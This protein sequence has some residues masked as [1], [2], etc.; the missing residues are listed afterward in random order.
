MCKKHFI[1]AGLAAALC[2]AGPSLYAQVTQARDLLKEGERLHLNYQFEHAIEAFS[3]AMGASDDSLVISKAEHARVHSEN[4]L[5]LSNYVVRPY[6][7]A[8]VVVPQRDFPLYYNLSPSGCWAYPPDLLLQYVNHKGDEKLPLFYRPALDRLV[9]AACDSLSD[10][11]WDIYMTE[12][13]FD[14]LVCWSPPVRL[15]PDINTQ[16]NEMY[17]VLSADGNTLYFCS[18]G[19]PG[20]GG[21]NL[22]VSRWDENLQNWSVPEN[23]GI[24]FSSTGNDMLYMLSDDLTYF[25]F[26]SDRNAP[27]D[28]LLLYKVEYE[29]SPVKIRPSSVQEL[30]EIAALSPKDSHPNADTG[31]SARSADTATSAHLVDT[32]TSA[33]SADAT[34]IR[35]TDTTDSR[36]AVS[37]SVLQ[38][39]RE[40]TQHYAQLSKAV[41]NLTGQVNK[42]EE[43][44]DSLRKTY[45]TLSREEDKSIFANHIR[46]EEFLLMELQQSLR[47]TQKSAQ[48]IEDMFLWYGVLA[49]PEINNTNTDLVF[50]AKTDVTPDAK[51]EVTSGAKADVFSPVKQKMCSLDDHVFL[52]P[53]PVEPPVDLTFRIEKQSVIVPWE[54][55]PMDLY[56]RI[57]L[58]T[59]SG[60]VSLNQLRGI[61]PAFEVKV[62]NRYV[63]YAGQ[64]QTYDQASQARAVVRRQGITGA[65]V[66]AFYE[67]KSISVQEGRRRETEK[68][69]APESTGMYQ[70]YLGAGEITPELLAA[71]SELT[72]K[73]IIRLA[74]GDAVDYFIGPF[75]SRAQAEEL[76]EALKEKGFALVSVQ[77]VTP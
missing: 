4:G 21:L 37:D 44:L 45:V 38:K 34:H 52:A 69:T 63:Y 53:V 41:R 22:F 40:A 8:S 17:P 10:T 23:M 18:D 36:T 60:K 35:A 43:K 31:T 70:V 42:Q 32:A 77:E 6:V 7:L 64:F 47:D 30:R 48:A 59:V 24:P 29:T 71:V 12:R 50:G 19:L 15:G 66:V 1:T 68:K 25:Y 61:S 11:G 16:G 65:L 51:S 49:V 33:R 9:F 62:G 5:I 73:D 3:R 74:K 75:S 39:T 56:Y 76:A 72:D 46:E 14:T 58:F 57:Q 27:K 13:T 55:E 54:N 26:V 2:I 28:S 67:G 20:L